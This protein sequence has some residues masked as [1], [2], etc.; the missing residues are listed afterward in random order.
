MAKNVFLANVDHGSVNTGW[1]MKIACER[2]CLAPPMRKPLHYHA[3]DIGRQR[4]NKSRE[5]TRGYRNEA[6]DTGSASTAFLMT[7]YVFMD[8]KG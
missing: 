5:A 3:T 7:W 2:P 6:N 1:K 4:C 8:G